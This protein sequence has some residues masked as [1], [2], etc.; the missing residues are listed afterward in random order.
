[1]K[2]LLSLCMLV[3]LAASCG[4]LD[5]KAQVGIK[6]DWTIS[7]VTYPGS[8]YIKVTSFDVA[9]SQCFVGS[10]WNFISNNNKGTMSLS[11][12]GCPSFTSPIVWTVTKDGSFTLKIT[13]GEKAKRVTQGYILK[14]QNQTETSFQLVDNVQVGGKTVEVV[15]NFSKL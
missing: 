3:V 7:S 4:S 11:K 1:M 9:D 8:D 6:G 14:V 5:Q 12:A 2:K 15:Y 10:S 13:E